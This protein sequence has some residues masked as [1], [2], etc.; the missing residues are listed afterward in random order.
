MRPRPRRPSARPDSPPRTRAK[1][2]VAPAPRLP[3]SRRGSLFR[4]PREILLFAL[5]RSRPALAAWE[6]QVPA[7]AAPG[8]GPH[9][10]PQPRPSCNEF[11]GA[12]SPLPTGRPRVPSPEGPGTRGH[13][14]VR[15]RSSAWREPGSV[16]KVAAM[17]WP[18]PGRGRILPTRVDVLGSAEHAAVLASPRAQGA[19]SSRP[20]G[21]PFRC[22]RG[23]GV[24]KT[25]PRIRRVVPGARLHCHGQ[26]SYGLVWAQM[27]KLG[28]KRK[29]PQQRAIA[30]AERPARPRAATGKRP[31]PAGKGRVC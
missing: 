14:R 28:G 9:A 16:S 6:H 29:P 26:D 19:R 12:G 17:P 21:R 3:W 5:S 2:G 30:G 13:L 20:G 8:A 25:L 15:L 18:K 27:R 22:S 7:P 10:R 23:C 11:R 24:S 1:Q 4:L 31:R